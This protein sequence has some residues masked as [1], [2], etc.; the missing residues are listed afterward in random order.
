[1]VLGSAVVLLL[2]A[3][4]FA[5]GLTVAHQ[6]G[7]NQ[8]IAMGARST[9]TTSSGPQPTTPMLQGNDDEPAAAVAAALGPAVVEIDVTTANSDGLG[10]GVVYDNSGLILTNAHVVEGTSQVKVQFADGSTTD[11]HVVGADTEADIAVVK[12]DGKDNLT[13][14]RLATD[15]PKVGEMAI[16]IG[17]P[18]GL[19]ETVTAGIVSAVDRP[20]EGEN[21]GP[22]TNMI[23]T[24]APINPG[25]S[26]G[27]LANRHGEVIGIN[28]SI[29]SQSGENNGIG[30]AIPI[31]SAKSVADKI[32]NGQ[33]L[34]HGYLGVGTKA[35][36]DGQPGALV[37]TVT[38]GDP[39]ANAGIKTGDVITALDGVAIKAPGDLSAQ[40]LAH[41]PGDTVKL[42]IR[43]DGQASTVTVQLG[44]RPSQLNDPNGQGSN[45]G[46]NQGNGQ[47]GS[48]PN[49]PPSSQRRGH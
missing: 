18:F 24:D 25:N 5:A 36:S 1:V 27:A 21:G 17:S 2:V 39:A 26:G 19:Q 32:V 3:G 11:G 40:I 10:S 22:T 9:T 14:A 35:S 23:Q 15:S 31:Q 33:P 42:D 16:G 29:Y 43:R 48:D 30:F 13:V 28:S 6:D 37:A 44:T 46:S 12:V 45:P 49:S 41:S 7:S 47:S 38:G 20:V 4:G 34:D 8:P